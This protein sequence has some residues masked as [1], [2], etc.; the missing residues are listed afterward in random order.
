MTIA[1]AI[2]GIPLKTSNTSTKISNGPTFGRNSYLRRVRDNRHAGLVKSEEHRGKAGLMIIALWLIW[3]TD[4][5]S[6]AVYVGSFPS[7][8][9]CEQA[10][11]QAKHVGPSPY[12]S[13]SFICVQAK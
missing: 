4:A 2:F 13:Y 3:M 6:G 12:P 11:Q 7:M 5:N 10:A 9:G 8:A 1:C